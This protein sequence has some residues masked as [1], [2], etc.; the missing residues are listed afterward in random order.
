MRYTWVGAMTILV[1]L[2][3]V[4][5]AQEGRAKHATATIA[6]AE[7]EGAAFGHG[8]PPSAPG[9]MFAGRPFGGTSARRCVPSVSD[10]SLPGGSLRSGEIIMRA[11][12][13]GPWGLRAGKES[14]IVWFPLHGATERGDTLLVRATRIGYPSDTLRQAIAGTGGR[15][16]SFSFPSAATFPAAGQW[17]VVASV[18]D[19]WGCFIL[20]VFK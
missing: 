3:Q 10:D 15:P 16:E 14:K 2:S 1:A 13:S 18:A 5:G 9:S 19:D 8:D 17:L 4:S 6:E 7:A 11:R 20:N 12:F